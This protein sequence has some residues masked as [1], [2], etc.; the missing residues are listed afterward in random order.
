VRDGAPERA[1]RRALWVGVDPL[2]IAGGLGE[3]VNLLLGHLHP[4]S[5]AELLSDQL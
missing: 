5:G 1:F 3:L 4:V 2:A